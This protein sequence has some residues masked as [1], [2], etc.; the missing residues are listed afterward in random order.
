MAGRKDRERKLAV[1][2]H[3]DVVGSTTLVQS[4][5]VIAHERMTDAFERL[6]TV[7]KSY[8]GTVHEVR[9]DALVAEV[10]RASDAVTAAA[11]FQSAHEVHNEQFSDNIVP[12]IRIGISLGEV[13]VADNTVTGPGIVLAQRVEQFAPPGGICVTAAIYEA[14][15]SRLPF[16]YQ[17]L[18][19]QSAKGFDQP[20]QIYGVKLR[21]GEQVPRPLGR[22][23]GI[24]WLRKRSTLLSLIA[25]L[26]IGAGI[27]VWYQL[28]ND[29][30]PVHPHEMAYALPDKPSIAVLPFTNIGAGNADE[31][32]SDGIPDSLII[33]L[34]AVPD[35]FVVGRNSSFRYKGEDVSPTEVAQAFGVR[36]VLNGTVQSSLDRL[37]ISVQ[38]ADTIDGRNVWSKQF[39]A[40]GGDPFAVQDEIT[41]EVVE[42]LNV[43][44]TVGTQTRSWIEM[45]GGSKP[46]VRFLQGRAHFQSWTSEGNAEAGRIWG[47]LLK[48]YPQQAY[49][50]MIGWVHWQ[51]AILSLSK[52]R[53]AELE[54]AKQLGLIAL[55]RHPE[56]ADIYAMLGI[57]SLD[58]G[59]H[60]SAL[61][62][63]EQALE[64][65]SGDAD[66]N[67]MA[68]RIMTMAGYPEEGITLLRRGMRY[69]PD[70]PHWVPTILMYAL[71]MEGQYEE[72][73]V[74]A[75]E[76]LLSKTNSVT[77]HPAALQNLVV[78]ADLTGR[79]TLAR[80][81]MIALLKESPGITVAT[82]RKGH[83]AFK[84]KAHANM[85]LDALQRAGLPES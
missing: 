80:K 74:I 82:V 58:M 38:L 8:G 41:R 60:D 62:Y 59:D 5:E 29:F 43:S 77:A 55:E 78:I 35:I 13:I 15:P 70:Y 63:A 46:F 25:G 47:E 21:G 14:A 2:I 18:G 71:I 81:H 33:A 20:V 54:I 7:I 22:R 69:E 61:V 1:L 67:S 76:L 24:F 48:E 52:D 50:F 4:N 73:E 6:A 75:T 45:S 16:D 34:T 42:Q 12:R 49:E 19:H 3:A 36:Y 66:I 23:A 56:Y 17:D 30:E 84:D 32:V 83:L 53:A 44:L 37:R 85:R 9:G 10:E 26:I 51:K 39:D 79:P 64:L 27:V 72:A 11:A 28:K 40:S 57:V 68:G 65:A 31:L